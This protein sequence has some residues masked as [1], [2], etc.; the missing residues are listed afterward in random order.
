MYLSQYKNGSREL[1]SLKVSQAHYGSF[2]HLMYRS[3]AFFPESVPY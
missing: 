1:L 3:H 2:E